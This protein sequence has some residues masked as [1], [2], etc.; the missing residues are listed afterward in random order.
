MLHDFY[1]VFQLFLNG[2]IRESALQGTFFIYSG[3]AV[4]LEE[5]AEHFSFILNNLFITNVFT[6][7]KIM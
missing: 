2:V 4:D 5:M 7:A 1:F 3:K 6:L